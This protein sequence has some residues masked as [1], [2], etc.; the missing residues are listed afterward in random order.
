MK[1][2]AFLLLIFSMLFSVVYAENAPLYVLNESNIN[3]VYEEVKNGV[4]NCE[5]VDVR[6][7][8]RGVVVSV[9]LLNPESEYY[10]ITPELNKTL[11]C[12]EY[13]LAKIKN[14]V[15]IEVHTKKV[16]DGIKMKN[17]EFSSVIAG[18]IGD[19]FVKKRPKISAERIYPVGYGEFMP[20]INTS[21]NGGND[22]DRIDII[23]Q[24]S[25]SGE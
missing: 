18:K 3:D 12:V 20:L 5:N 23:I 11:S 4:M 10:R 17:W 21:N 25:I 8:I 22:G 1:K 16:P 14:P 19:M 13:F 7:E 24:S 9:T 6:K 2:S 15:I